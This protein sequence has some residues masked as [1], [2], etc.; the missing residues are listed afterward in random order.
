M[1]M[2]SQGCTTRLGQGKTAVKKGRGAHSHQQ[3]Q[4]SQ[5]KAAGGRKGPI[6]R[7]NS[8]FRQSYTCKTP[9]QFNYH[10]QRQFWGTFQGPVM[11]N[12]SKLT[13]QL[14][15]TSLQAN[16]GPKVERDLYQ[17]THR[18]LLNDTLCDQT[19]TP[20]HTMRIHKGLGKG[21]CRVLAPRT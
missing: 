5:G 6:D 2:R 4:W 14:H 8:D 3:I 20:R 19:R 17:Q 11:H 10:M 18:S 13:I 7:G 15:R 21:G 1:S 16:R 12:P 9:T